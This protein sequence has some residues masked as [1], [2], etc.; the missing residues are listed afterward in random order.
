[1]RNLV[2]GLW[3]TLLGS[4]GC[5]PLPLEPRDPD[6]GAFHFRVQTYNLFNEGGGNVDTLAALGQSDADVI[7]LQETTAV[8]QEAIE[9]RFA[10][11]YPHRAFKVDTTGAAAGLGILSRFPVR[12]GGF[13]PGPNGWHPAWCHLVDTPHG[14]VK[15]LN[16]H[17][18]SANGQNGNAIQ[19][20]LRTADDHRYEISLFMSQS[21]MPVVPM[22]VAGD[23]NEGPDGAAIQYLEGVGFRNILPLYHPGQPTWRYD[24][25]VGGQFTQELD[26]ILFDPSFEPLNAWVVNSGGSDHLAVVAHLQAAA[27][28]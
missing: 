13:L 8:W 17:L 6:P 14:T 19:S 23:F 5:G 1:M 10:A 2:L 16:T 24:R 22:I 9:S 20:Y 18:R 28:W 27:S 11:R 25:S 15:I 21:Q 3:A 4:S 12:D 7:C 26:H